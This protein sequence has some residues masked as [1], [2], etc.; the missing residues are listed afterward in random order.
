MAL[1][2]CLNRGRFQD[3]ARSVLD[4]LEMQRCAMLMFISCGWFWDEIS[5]TETVQIMRHAARAMR[6][7]RAA[8]G[9]GLELPKFSM[10]RRLSPS[11]N[12]ALRN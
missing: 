2:Y 12:G 9:A 4:L 8:A 5:G 3:R 7:A 11:L 10:A 6:D 1:A